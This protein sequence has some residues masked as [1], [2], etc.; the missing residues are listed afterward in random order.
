M[1]IAIVKRAFQNGPY[2]GDQVEYWQNEQ[3]IILCI[4]DGLGHGKQAEE[5]ALAAVEYVAHHN[6]LPLQDLFAGCDMA[7][8]GTR[9]V[10]MGIAIIDQDSETLTYAGIGNTRAVI[11]NSNSL[12]LRSD[13]GIVGAGFRKL[14]PETLPFCPGNLVILTTD[15]IKERLDL[16]DY[17]KALYTNLDGF[18]EQILLDGGRETDDATVLVF[19]NES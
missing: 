6:S 3:K 10:A 17:N 5:A 13:W 14:S 2:C 4:V 19:R 12:S 11:L 8:R 15:G 16:S 18:A 7:L 9:G 1:Q